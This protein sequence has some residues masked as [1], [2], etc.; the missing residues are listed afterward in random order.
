MN[1][2]LNYRLHS[3]LSKSLKIG[4]SFAAGRNFT[5]SICVNHKS[6]G[7]KRKHT[8]IDY[9]RRVNTFGVVSRIMKDIN[10]TAFIASIIYEN[11]LFS[12]I[13]LPEGVTVGDKLYSGSQ[14]QVD[15]KKGYAVLLRY[16]SLFTV[17]NNVELKPYTGST[18]SRAAGASCLLVGKKQQNVILKLKSG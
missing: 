18:L 1:K 4:T 2:V 15:L 6:G 9:Y 5:G 13:I 14:E 12:Y 10:R 16:I 3:Y 17:V 7:V 8:F 11:G